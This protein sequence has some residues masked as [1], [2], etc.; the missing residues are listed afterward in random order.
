MSGRGR[1]PLLPSPFL[2]AP[3]ATPY[4][5][6]DSPACAGLPDLFFE[7]ERFAEATAICAACPIRQKCLDYALDSEAYG[8]WGGLTPEERDDLRG[9][10]LAGSPEDRFVSFE[11][12]RR[13]AAGQPVADVAASADVTERTLHRWLAGARGEGLG[14]AA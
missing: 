9:G 4:G 5:P 11:I 7:E 13:V 1:K 10:P 12:R 2:P 14:E 8:V 6:D 3:V